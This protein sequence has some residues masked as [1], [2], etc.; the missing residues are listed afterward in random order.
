MGGDQDILTAGREAVRMKV[1]E[2]VA[3]C[4]SAGQA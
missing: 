3:T 1:R 2:L 4:G